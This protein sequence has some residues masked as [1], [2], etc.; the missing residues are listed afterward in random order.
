MAKHNDLGKWGEDEAVRFLESK[1]YTILE[2]DWKFGRRDLDIVALSEDGCLLAVVEVKT[3]STE[4][5]TEPEQ[6]VDGAKKRN[7]AI[8]ANAY[9]KAH[10]VSQE[11]RFDIVSIVGSRSE[12]KR[13]DHIVDAFNPM[14][15]L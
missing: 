5:L 11:I 7:L 1:G 9:V 8:A 12:V 14:L 10:H 3:R 4:D 13:I 15:I 2:R 6:A